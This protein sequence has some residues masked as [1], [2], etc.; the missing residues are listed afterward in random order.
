M[1]QQDFHTVSN[2]LFAN[3]EKFSDNDYKIAIEALSRIAEPQMILYTMNRICIEQMQTD[4]EED[5][6]LVP[7]AET[8]Q[9]YL[10]KNKNV[11]KY[12]REQF[13]KVRCIKTLWGHTPVQDKCVNLSGIIVKR[14]EV[15]DSDSEEEE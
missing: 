15:E 13:E 11:Q 10:P 12:V 6:L 8:V 5:V 3:K 1:S 14:D 7:R 2:I 9:F 4:G